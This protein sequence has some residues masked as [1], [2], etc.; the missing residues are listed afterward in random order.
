MTPLRDKLREMGLYEGT[1][2][3]LLCGDIVEITRRHNDEPLPRFRQRGHR[4]VVDPGTAIWFC[5]WCG[6]EW[7]T[8]TRGADRAR[9]RCHACTMIIEWSHGMWMPDGVD[10]EAPWTLG[11][12]TP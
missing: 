7:A 9:K 10:R 2:V 12:P 1:R 8:P 6:H 5:P 11:L 3:R 4:A